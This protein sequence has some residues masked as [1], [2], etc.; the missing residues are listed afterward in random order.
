ME[1][2]EETK[3]ILITRKERREREKE[4]TCTAPLTV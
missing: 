4:I 1:R 2:K 3:Y